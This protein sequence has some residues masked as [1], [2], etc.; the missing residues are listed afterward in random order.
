M[1]LGN[2]VDAAVT[3]FQSLNA[4]TGAWNGRTLTAGA[5]ISISNGTGT[6]GNPTITSLGPPTYTT[7]SFTPGIAFGGSAVGITYNVASTAGQYTQIGNVVF[8]SIRVI[9]TSKG[10]AVGAATITGLPVLTGPAI[11]FCQ[12]NLFSSFLSWDAGYTY[13]LVQTIPSSTTMQINENI[14]NRNSANPPLTNTAFANNTEIVSTGFY[15]T[16]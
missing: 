6:A 15:F 13:V 10:A 16:S 14:I 12:G 5:G 11:P 1:A 2:P 7:G 9:M 8:Y 3:G 4:A